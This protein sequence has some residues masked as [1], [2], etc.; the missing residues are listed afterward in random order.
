M[1]PVIDLWKRGEP[2][3]VRTM[4]DMAA[5]A[6]VS[7][8]EILTRSIQRAFRFRAARRWLA[9]EQPERRDAHVAIVALHT[10]MTSYAIPD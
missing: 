9:D 6:E 5:I 3:L 7:L 10:R 2:G 1:L 8:W 4:I